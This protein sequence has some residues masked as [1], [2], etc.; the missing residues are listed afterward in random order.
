MLLAHQRHQLLQLGKIADI[1]AADRDRAHR[2]RRDRQ[3]RLAAEQADDDELTALGERVIAEL[4]RR[5]CADAIDHGR[6]LAADR[7]LDLV[8]RV[9][10]RPVDRGD[11]TGLQC[12]RALGRIDVDQH[13]PAAERLDQGR[14]H[15]AETAG[16]DDHDRLTRQHV[17]RDLLER[18]VGRETGTGIGRHQRRIEIADVDQVACV[19][20]QD[21]LGIAAMAMHAEKARGRTEILVAGQADRAF[22]AADPGVDQP[23]IADR[24]SGGVGPQGHDLADR[25]MAHGERQPD[26][27]VLERQA[28]AGAQIV[29]ALPDMQIAVADSG[30]AHLEQHLGPGGRDRRIIMGRQWLTEFLDLVAPHCVSPLIALLHW[31][32]SNDSWR[33]E[34]RGKICYRHALN[35]GG[36]AA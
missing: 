2:D 1:G 6:G 9:G 32:A 22:A 4:H 29:A 33:G 8:E 17:D 30:R 35:K 13:R 23:D 14:R 36:S 24:D 20:H 18:A 10:G 26:A 16:A 7:G 34:A 19:R 21:L 5:R 25:L 27:A 11:G 31:R 12:R 3:G 28:L 15:Q